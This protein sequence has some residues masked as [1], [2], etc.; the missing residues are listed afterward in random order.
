MYSLEGNQWNL[1]DEIK[2]NEKL[3]KED[4]DELHNFCL[5]LPRADEF[6][7]TGKT[8]F[9]CVVVLKLF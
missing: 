1:E 2:K 4:V 6:T 9:K 8:Q 5:T 7:I 3:R